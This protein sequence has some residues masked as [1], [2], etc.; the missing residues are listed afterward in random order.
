MPIESTPV[1]RCLEKKT[2]VLGFEVLDL[3]AIFLLLSILNFIF[4]GTDLK[5][6]LV[7]IPTLT[8]AGTIRFAKRGKPENF[9][10]HW[11]RFQIRPGVLSAF[12]DPTRTDPR[13]I[14]A[15]EIKR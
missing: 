4:G 3:L 13:K 10:F 1:S 7:W 14:A 6:F 8:V 12:E 15:T 11:I 2:I 5:I 9:L